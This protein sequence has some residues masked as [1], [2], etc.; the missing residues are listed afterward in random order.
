MPKSNTTKK[1]M[2]FKM[3]ILTKWSLFSRGAA[4]MAVTAACGLF[5]SFFLPSSA[6]LASRDHEP[7]IFAASLAPELNPGLADLK[8]AHIVS[9]LP[10]GAF[11]SYQTAACIF[12]GSDVEAGKA[13]KSC[14]H[15]KLGILVPSS[16]FLM[17]AS[18]NSSIVE[19]SNG[20]GGWRLTKSPYG[21][22][23]ESATELGEVKLGV[24]KEQI[25][26]SLVAFLRLLSNGSKTELSRLELMGTP[27]H[28]VVTWVEGGI[29]NQF[30][31]NRQDLLCDKQIRKTPAGLTVLK[32]T[33]YKNVQGVMLPYRIQM[34]GPSGKVISTEVVDAWTLGVIW[35][36]NFFTPEGF[37]R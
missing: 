13:Q 18:G 15:G 36:A 23:T 16:A 26:H 11:D 3:K 14:V 32:Y 7:R 20:E 37:R 9:R 8:R 12:P 6:A 22:P 17:I 30:F 21:T 19:L 24:M 25:A 10:A 35:P 1:G 2:N 34:E 4:I 31:F 28:L 5:P 33:Q 29:S 27:T